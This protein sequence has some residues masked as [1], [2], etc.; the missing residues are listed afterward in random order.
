[1]LATSERVLVLLVAL[2]LAVS[3]A[4][5]VS[6]AAEVSPA[7]EVTYSDPVNLSAVGK[8]ARFPVVEADSQGRAFVAWQQH[9][10]SDYSIEA[11]RIAADG[12]V[13]PVQVLASSD[14][15][16]QSE[17]LLGLDSQGEAT[18]VW[19]A[20]SGVI[21]AVRVDSAG[22][23][24]AIRTISDSSYG[25]SYPDLAI[26][27]QGRV[28]V[29]W[30]ADPDGSGAGKYGIEVVRLG[31]DGAPGPIHFVSDATVPSFQA[32]VAVDPQGRATVAWMELLSPRRVAAVRIGADGT[33]GV[34]QVV[35]KPT[36]GFVAD[37]QPI[38]AADSQGDAVIAMPTKTGQDPER[39]SSIRLGANGAFG[40]RQ[41]LSSAGELEAGFPQLA[42][43]SAN[44]PTMAWSIFDSSESR[45][46]SVRLSS[47]GV[48]GSPQTLSAPG[49]YAMDPQ[50]A[51][52]SQDMATVIW[53]RIEGSGSRIRAVRLSE[54]GTPEVVQTLSGPDHAA[55]SPHIAFDQRDRA[56]IVWSAGSG[57]SNQI[58]MVQSGG[59]GP[60]QVKLTGTAIGSDSAYLNLS[61]AN[62]SDQGPIDSLAY[63]G[64]PEAGIIFN[65]NPYRPENRGALDVLIGP[66]PVLPSSIP[67]SSAFDTGYVVQATQPGI[68]QVRTTV[69]GIDSEGNDVSDDAS[70]EVVAIDVELQRQQRQAIFAGAYVDFAYQAQAAALAEADKALGGIG[71]SLR[72]ILPKQFKSR[73]RKTTPAER[74]L[75]ELYGLPEGSLSFLPD[76]VANYLLFAET[77]QQAEWQGWKAKIKSGARK[78]F[79]DPVLFWD[80][81][82]RG[83]DPATK[84]Q[85]GQELY[86]A[87]AEGAAGVR[88]FA[89]DAYS[90]ID[91]DTPREI[92]RGVEPMIAEAGAKARRS[93][94]HAY[95][96]GKGEMKKLVKAFKRNDRVGVKALAT[97]LAGKEVDFYAEVG[98]IAVGDLVTGGVLDKLRALDKAS[99]ASRVATALESP[100]INSFDDLLIRTIDDG[101]VAPTAAELG[102]GEADQ[103][104]VSGVLNQLEEKAA[105][106]GYP[107]LKLKAKFRSRGYSAPGSIGK[108]Q[109]IPTKT[110][111]ALDLLLGMDGSGL[112][113]NAI[114]KPKL[115]KYFK[116]LPAELKALLNE[117]LDEQLGSYKKWQQAKKGKGKMAALYKATKSRR[118]FENVIKHKEGGKV[119]EVVTSTI[120]MELETSKRGGTELLKY[121]E[122]TVDGRKIVKRRPRGSG[123]G[124]GSDYDGLSLELANGEKL[125]PGIASSMWLEGNRL[126][127]KA[128]AEKGFAWGFHGLSENAFD[129]GSEL[130][131]SKIWQYI[132]EVMPKD[133][134]LRRFGKQPAEILDKMTFGQ[135]V[136]T[137]TADGA[138]VGLLGQ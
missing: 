114:F 50:L 129:F 81:Q 122:L 113:G 103:A 98:T 31:T 51:I 70:L 5:E 68:V 18:V 30:Q 92:M 76:S 17:P 67:A 118:T 119:V 130:F 120:K 11:V 48:P 54:N 91:V 64:G 121:R 29:A 23:V 127:T 88:S 128:A 108:N 3:L 77:R 84:F 33:P 75:A 43:D 66:D 26:D 56:T 1:L 89:K 36:E 97:T 6:S 106:Q 61:V 116:K 136:I 46:Q 40:S 132:A 58:Q 10:G 110:G 93:A 87:A 105:R 27:A 96:I 34:A 79:K 69:E 14:V 42:I 101:R 94:K 55:T 86:N 12:E 21:K 62:L 37:E 53:R 63:P 2:G 24:G 57:A 131:H 104:I 112:G 85:V 134:A 4:P 115:P 44:R 16:S 8:D 102:M 82:F 123:V 83:G 19:S 135:Y 13:G 39:I 100:P 117:R 32:Q 90:L 49:E 124:I 9:S 28:T 107:G 78:V 138:G 7:A 65:T 99:K 109:F 125:P 41:E 133:E 71:K 38:V 73:V 47:A 72:K 111:G 52:D 74:T 60:L 80:N 35:P 95:K 45:V 126:F 59:G 137:V 22:A 20:K 15:S 25:S